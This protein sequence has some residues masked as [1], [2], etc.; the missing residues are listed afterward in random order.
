[1]DHMMP[2]MD[3][4]ETTAAIR[5]LGGEYFKRVPI[6]ALTANAVSGMKEMFLANSFDDFISKPVEISKLNGIME[7]W[8]PNEKRVMNA[9]KT[10]KDASQAETALNI[11]GVDAA[12][13]LAMTGGTIQGY[14]MVLKQYCKDAEERLSFMARFG[15]TQDASAPDEETTRLFAIHAHALKSASASIGAEEVSRIAAELEA[16]G[17]N[18]D[19]GR[20]AERLDEFREKLSDLVGRIKAGISAG[21]TKPSEMKQSA[22]ADIAPLMARLLSALTEEDIGVVDDTLSELSGMDMDEETR[23]ALSKISDLALVSDFAG[24]LDALRCSLPAHFCEA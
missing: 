10:K 5:A 19:H 1:M 4:V 8:V 16:A 3:G 15:E 14:I 17:K 11:E 12:Q 6:I 23:D 22:D 18:T 9:R 2:D 21:E 7:K 20:I 24:A 13:G